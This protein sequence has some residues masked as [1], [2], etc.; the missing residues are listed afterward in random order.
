MENMEVKNFWLNKRVLITG[1]TG[2]KGSWL[3]TWLLRKQAKLYGFSLNMKQE[4][5]IY[6]CLKGE[7]SFSEKIEDIRSH[8]ILQSYIEEIQPQIIF[9]MAA[10]P[11]VRMSYDHPFDTW[12]INTL[13][14]VNLLNSLKVIKKKCAVIIITTDKVYKNKDTSGK[15]ISFKETDELL[16]SD[17][18]SA[19]KAASEIAINS[20]IQS[21]YNHT[22]ILHL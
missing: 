6:E 9:H 1:H 10:Q 11:L 14:T 21:F 15:L 4:Y 13:G 22:N 16:G 3:L 18:Y 20:W 17:P 2:F 7:Y 12:N 5:S 8:S 19:S